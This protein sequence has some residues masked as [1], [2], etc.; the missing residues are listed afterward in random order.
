LTAATGT[1]AKTSLMAASAVKTSSEFFAA[2]VNNPPLRVDGPPFDTAT[3]QIAGTSANT[4]I[5]Y[6]GE[7]STDPARSSAVA[8][9]DTALV[10]SYGT[11]ANEQGISW[12]VQ[13][14]ATLAAMTFS[15]TDPDGQARSQALN[16]R[17]RPNLD[18]PA[19]TQKVEN[20]QAEIAA[21][22][23]SIQGSKDRHQQLGAT[24]SDF[25]NQVKGVS[26]EEVGAQ[27]LALQTRLSASLQTTAMLYQTSLINYLR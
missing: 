26:N 14:V 1:L 21:T 25:L 13:N 7:A 6:T 2:D 11:R 23:N 22:Q 18:V 8:R 27:I 16:D 4:V 10:V 9:V 15:P 5:W 17:L 12:L 24:L 20:I 19:G 3:A